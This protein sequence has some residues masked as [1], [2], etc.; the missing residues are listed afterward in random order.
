MDMI[1]SKLREIVKDREA[2]RASVHGVMKSWTRLSSWTTTLLRWYWDY[3]KGFSGGSDGKESACKAQD[4]DSIPGSG[5][6]P[7]KWMATCSSVLA[8]RIPW[9]EE[10]GGRQS[11]GLQSWTQQMQLSTEQHIRIFKVSENSL[12][13][14]F[15]EKILDSAKRKNWVSKK[16]SFGETQFSPSVVSDSLQPH[17]L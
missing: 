10:P 6:S 7:E 15:K 17:G 16:D 3:A 14:F 9:T 12:C 2:W 13:I 5:R 11:I 8:W 1:W 4:T